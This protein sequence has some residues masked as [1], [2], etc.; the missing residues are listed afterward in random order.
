MFYN[1]VMDHVTKTIPVKLNVPQERIEDLL[2]I[3]RQFNQAC[4]MV[5]ETAWAGEH[6]TYNRKEVHQATYYQVREAT[7]LPANLV[8]AARNRVCDAVKACVIRWAKGERASKPTFRALG[9]VAYDKRTVTIKDR[10]CTLATVNGRVRAEYVMGEY[11]RRHLDDPDY[12]RRSATLIYREGAFFLH[13]VL[14]K[15]VTYRQT[16]V[17]MG[18]DLGVSRLAVTSTGRFFKAGFYNWKRNH[19]FRTKR[20]LQG[21]GTRGAKRVLKRLRGRENRFAEDYI[22]QVSKGIVEEALNHQVDTIVFEELDHIRERMRGGNKRSQRQ[23]HSWA[24]RKLQAFVAYK[25]AEV[26]IA[27]AWQDAR[28]TS[29]T[30]SRCGHRDRSNRRGRAFRC[31]SCGYTADADYNAAKM[32]GLKSCT[33]G[34]KT[35]GVGLTRQLALKSGTLTPKGEYLASCG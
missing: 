30:C 16:G 22:H 32:I 7:D 19:G 34:Q 35:A 28:Y 15:R 26:G 10:S 14:R 27:V 5:L 33:Q 18:V 8:C 2:E 9:S 20:S 11:Q 13:I 29:Q 24:F 4:T 6:K 31:R 12:R 21:K 17:V 3:F 25:A 23:M 1:S